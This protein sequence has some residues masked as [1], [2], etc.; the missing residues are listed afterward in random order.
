MILPVRRH[1]LSPSTSR[2]PPSFADVPGELLSTSHLLT[3]NSPRLQACN[4]LAKGFSLDTARF[5]LCC[6]KYDAP[7]V[8]R[9]SMPS[10][11]SPV[12]GVRVV[13]KV[14]GPDDPVYLVYYRPQYLLVSP[15]SLFM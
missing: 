10:T 15:L 4:P 12:D 7:V 6:L 8:C 9:P 3:L 1:G 5:A 11:P 14:G 2:N 13:W